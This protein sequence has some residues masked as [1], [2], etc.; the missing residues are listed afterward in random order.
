M[1]NFCKKIGTSAIA[2]PFFDEYMLSCNRS[3]NRCKLDKV[4]GDSNSYR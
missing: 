4:Q 1:N 2:I 3:R